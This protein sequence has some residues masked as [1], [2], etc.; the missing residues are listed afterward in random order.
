[1]AT[2]AF[3]FY[4][5]FVGS[6]DPLHIYWTVSLTFKT[7]QI[8]VKNCNAILDTLYDLHVALQDSTRNGWWKRI[9]VY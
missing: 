7:I 9:S 2:Y 4:R 8:N 1:M 6:I 3:S 5:G